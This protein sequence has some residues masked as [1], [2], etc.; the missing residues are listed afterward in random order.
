MSLPSPARVH[1]VV[2]PAAGR[3]GPVLAVLDR[4]FR[5]AEVDWQVR[6]VTIDCDPPQPVLLDGEP[7]GDTPVTVEVVPQALKVLVPA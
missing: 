6:R 1:V 7:L 2:N 3:P 5:E 4:V